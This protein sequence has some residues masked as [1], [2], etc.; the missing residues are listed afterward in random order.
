MCSTTRPARPDGSPERVVRE[1]RDEDTEPADASQYYLNRPT[2]PPDSF[3]T[4][5]M[6][7]R[8]AAAG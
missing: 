1:I 5:E 7:E 6:L 8:P 2:S 3:I 4:A